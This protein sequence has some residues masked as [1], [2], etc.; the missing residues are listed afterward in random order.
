M[1]HSFLVLQNFLRT[2]RK[3]GIIS[4]PFIHWKIREIH[5]N[6][7]LAMHIPSD[8]FVIIGVEVVGDG[9]ICKLEY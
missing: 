4:P 9:Y 8:N 5:A 2:I 1:F 3:E 7:Y 6:A